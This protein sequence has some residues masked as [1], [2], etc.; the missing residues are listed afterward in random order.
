MTSICFVRWLCAL[1]LASTAVRAADEWKVGEWKSLFNGRDLSGW[2][3][4]D[5]AGAGE[6]KVEDGELVLNTGVALTGIRRTNGFPRTNYEILVTATKKQGQDFFS[7][8]TFPVGETNVTFINGGWGGA[9]V[10]ISSIDG[11]D[12]SENMTTAFW[13]FEKDQPYEF[14]VRVL[15]DKLQA[16]IDGEKIIDA[17]IEGRK[18]SMRA[19]EIDLSVPLGI[20]TYQTTATIQEI[21]IRKLPKELKKIAFIAGSKSHG[22]GEHEYKKGLRLLRDAIEKESGLIA[23]D[24]DVHLGGWPVD[25]RDLDDA[26]T[27]VVFCDGSDHDRDD[28]PLVKYSRWKQ[29]ERQMERGAGLVCLHYSLFV[30]SEDL[31]P[32]FLDWIGGYFDYENGSG[33]RNWHSKIETREFSILPATPGHPIL[34]GVE[35]FTIQEEYY[36]NIRFPEDKEGLTPIATF[37]PEKKDWSKVVGWAYERE[38][39]GRGFGYTG[40]HFHE[41]WENPEVLRMIVNAILWTA[42]ADTAKVT[43]GN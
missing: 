9:L 28:H 43:A 19:G 36:F 13:K 25:D 22:P 15:D 4:V 32:K 5:Y 1:A 17:N 16:F 42:K 21:K 18:I 31:G 30:P 11:M 33:P 14:R 29:I 39:G 10:G 2:E 7:A 35:P 34:E 12:A 41:N 3:V 23:V 40:G 20:S 37:D 38:N 6:V 24:T 26:D 8:I 27:I